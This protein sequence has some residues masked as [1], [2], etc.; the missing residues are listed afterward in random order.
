MHECAGEIELILHGNF[1]VDRLTRPDTVCRQNCVLSHS[2]GTVSG[3]QYGA[4]GWLAHHLALWCPLFRSQCPP[5]MIAPTPRHLQVAWR[6]SLL[7]KP[8]PLHQVARGLIIRL[9]V[10]LQPM[11]SQYPKG[12][13]NHRAQSFW[14]VPSPSVRHK[15]IVPQVSRTER[16]LHNLIDVNNAREFVRRGSHPVS[17]VGW[18]RDSFEVGCKR[19]PRSW[20]RRPMTVQC[21]ASGNCCQKLVSAL[22]CWC[23]K[24]ASH[25]SL[26][27]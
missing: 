10:S 18:L 4:V 14:H 6:K 17:Y 12:L 27:G 22:P 16:A 1:L 3:R 11:E 23:L 2:A 5:F 19:F 24:N 20:R 9:D 25:F 7:P 15:R 26:L 13:G 21:P 8:Q